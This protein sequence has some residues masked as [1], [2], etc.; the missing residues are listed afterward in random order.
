MQ[1]AQQVLNA[2]DLDAAMDPDLGTPRVQQA[3]ATETELRDLVRLVRLETGTDRRILDTTIAL[4]DP[5]G[6]PRQ[7]FC[8]LRRMPDPPARPRTPTA[9]T[10]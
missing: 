1:C 8:S 9:P 3:I 7:L 2:V 6:E 4:F 5:G 10:A